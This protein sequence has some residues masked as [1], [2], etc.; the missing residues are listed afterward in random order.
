M[1]ILVDVHFR[2]ETTPDEAGNLKIVNYK[3]AARGLD[4]NTIIS[5]EILQRDEI[6][7]TQSSCPCNL[8]WM[9]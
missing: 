2:I 9:G 4:C 6:F 8:W 1:V 3:S 7:V 5:R